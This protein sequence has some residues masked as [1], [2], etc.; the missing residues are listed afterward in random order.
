MKIA[1][2]VPLFLR[3]FSADGRCVFTSILIEICVNFFQ[4]DLLTKLDRTQRGIFVF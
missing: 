3:A 4:R 2:H 1:V